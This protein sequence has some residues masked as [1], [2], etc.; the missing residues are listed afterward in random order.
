[1]VQA[2]G[3]PSPQYGYYPPQGTTSA[4]SVNPASYG[5]SYQQ[6]AYSGGSYYA[7][8]SSIASGA[9]SAIVSDSSAASRFSMFLINTPDRL[10]KV[11]AGMGG[12]GRFFVNMLAGSVPLFTSSAKQQEVSNNVRGWLSSADLVRT[13]ASPFHSNLLQDVGI[14]NAQ[15]L[16]LYVN[17]ADQGI[18]TQRLMGAAAARGSG[19]VPNQSMVSNWVQLAIQLPKYNY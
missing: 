1:M 15:D 7:Q 16:S 17:P 12:V 14:W 9:I 4:Q 18:L 11:G 6:D 3:A 13:G 2:V 19:D 8:T 10:L 5:S